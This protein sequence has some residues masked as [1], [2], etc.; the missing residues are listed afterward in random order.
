MNGVKVHAISAVKSVESV[1]TVPHAPS[2]MTS[3][4]GTSA[5]VRLGSVGT[6]VRS[7]MTTAHLTLADLE[8]ALM[9]STISSVFVHS[10]PPRQAA[11]NVIINFAQIY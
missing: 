10:G 3:R 8:N 11:R 1:R 7:T 2:E 9:T 5:L 6:P 4:W